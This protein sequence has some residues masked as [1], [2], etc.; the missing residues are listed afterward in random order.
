MTLGLPSISKSRE[1]QRSDELL[2]I[3]KNTR[4]TSLGLGFWLPGIWILFLLFTVIFADI[5]PIQSPT[6][7]DF[8]NLKSRPNLTYWLGT[9]VLARDIFSRVIYGARVS[10]TVAFLAPVFGMIIGLGLGMLAGYFKGI[11]ESSIMG[12]IDIILAFPNIVLAMVILFFAGADII[13]LIVVLTVTSIPANTRIARASTLS[14]SEREFVLA[15]RAQGASDLRI[16]LY[17]ILPNILLPNLAYILSFMSIII[18]IEGSLSFLGVGIPP[19]TPT[20]GG[21]IAEGFAD[22]NTDP[23][24]SFMPALVLF[25]TVLSLNL[26]GDCFRRRYAIR[27]S[28]L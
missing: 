15:A 18:M 13:N 11:A 28:S 5:L 22:I 24:L 8:S 27:E 10:L 4:S 1:A 6:E 17:E 9:D 14:Y 2:L 19:P 23:H 3:G 7:S 16:L 20:W 25:L 21:M 12:L 26:I